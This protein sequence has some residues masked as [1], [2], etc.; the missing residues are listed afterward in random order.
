[1]KVKRDFNDINNNLK[2]DKRKEDR[3]LIIQNIQ[4]NNVGLAINMVT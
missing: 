2:K 1:M 4:T 3:K